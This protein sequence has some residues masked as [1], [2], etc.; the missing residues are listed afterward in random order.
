MTVSEGW[1]LIGAAFKW[2]GTQ[3][4]GEG[5]INGDNGSSASGG[6]NTMSSVRF[7]DSDTYYACIG[8]KRTGT[9]ATDGYAGY[10]RSLKHHFIG[11]TDNR[12]DFTTACATGCCDSC[13]ATSSE[14]FSSSDTAVYYKW[15]TSRTDTVVNWIDTIADTGDGTGPSIVLPSTDPD[16]ANLPIFT[17][18]QGLY[19]ETTAQALTFTPLALNVNS[20]T[21]SM[22]ARN[23]GAGGAAF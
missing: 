22:F 12:A 9:T 23:E 5:Y 19:F 1:Q 8:G 4:T 7:V 21:M 11:I 20:F 6:P 18:N 15:D 14:C 13:D 3:M 2:D 10:I 17:H 16:M